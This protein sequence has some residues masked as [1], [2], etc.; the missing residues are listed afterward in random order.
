[1]SFRDLPEQARMTGAA[2][3][4]LSSFGSPFTQNERLFTL[5]FPDGSGIA[6]G[7]LLPHH[8][9]GVELLS[10]TY[11]YQVE[12]FS[13]DA[14][15]EAK[16]FLAQPAEITILL[17][18]GSERLITGIVTA[19]GP[20]GADGGMARYV[21]HLEPC[22]AVLAHRF[23]ACVRQEMTVP[24]VLKDVFERHIQDNPI[25][26]RTFRVEFRLT[27]TYPTLSYCNQYESD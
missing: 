20:V 18:D 11:L 7:T 12:I 3:S 27:S 1:M 21:L 5:N 17:A 14:F 22:L 16:H 24:D 6:D 10:G 4:I 23:N 13:A 26:Q 8:L 19:F 15:L 25:I 9:R 2:D